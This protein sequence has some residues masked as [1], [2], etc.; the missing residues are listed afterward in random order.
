MPYPKPVPRLTSEQFEQ[1]LQ[2][3]EEF[4]VPDE[5][6]RDLRRHREALNAE[7]T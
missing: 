7:D 6:E 2:E 1:F 3:L 4:E 5:M